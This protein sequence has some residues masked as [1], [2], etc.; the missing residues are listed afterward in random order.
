MKVEAE[1]KKRA[2]LLGAM[3]ALV[4]QPDAN[5]EAVF[6]AHGV[7][8]PVQGNKRPATK[9]VRDRLSKAKIDAWLKT[10]PAAFKKLADGGALFLVAQ[11]SGNASWQMRV[12]PTAAQVA[13]AVKRQ[14]ERASDGKEQKFWRP[15]QTISLGV[16]PEVSLAEAREER[17]RLRKQVKQGLDPVVERKVARVESLAASGVTFQAVAELWL[18][19]EK[20]GWSDVHYTKSARALER[21]VYPALGAIPIGRISVPMVSAVIDRVQK[22][23]GGRRETAAKLLQHV[24]SVFRFAQAKGLRPDNPAEPVI[25]LLDVAPPV[26][27]HPALLQWSELGDI[28]RR[29]EVCNA[30]PAVRLCNRLLAYTSV[31]LANG[32]AAR[33]QDMDL[34][35][36]PARWSIPRQSMKGDLEAKAAG[37]PHTVFL[38]PHLVEHLRRW[39]AA[40]PAKAVYLFKGNQGR[41]HISKEAV[42]KMLRV[43]LDLR[44]KHTPHGWRSAFSTRAKDDTKFDRELIELTLDHET[45]TSVE[46]A[47]DRGERLEKRLPLAMWW[48]EQLSKAEGQP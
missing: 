41:A 15:T 14:L 1:Q 21:D 18:A 20:V 37:V 5:V 40:Q 42:E 4:E 44:D 7:E 30:S 27:G 26:Q 12:P 25:E 31:R 36:V 3:K 11:R 35:A 47:Y 33:W 16:Y 8:P 39:K 28:L 24:K 10:E 6:K 38:H 22:R 48:Q 46:A 34:D 19:K 9:R 2:R 43:T 23:G 17:D 32:V 29:A 13:A 45:K